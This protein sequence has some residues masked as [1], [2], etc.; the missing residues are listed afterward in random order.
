MLPSSQSQTEGAFELIYEED[1]LKAGYRLHISR[2]T[3]IAGHVFTACVFAAISFA[4]LAMAEGFLAG[5][6]SLGKAGIAIA[7]GAAL[8]YAIAYLNRSMIGFGFTDWLKKMGQ[9][10]GTTKY[11]YDAHR[12]V[13]E[14][15]MFG[16]EM[17]WTEAHGW[18][19]DEHILLIY[20]SPV[21]YYYLA[22]TKVP[23]HDLS[24]LTAILQTAKVP[25]L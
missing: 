12:L 4:A 13:I 18:T 15:R 21:F 20:R 17:N 7:I 25:R 11:I 14:D 23:D 1:N 10:A 9:N 6:G 19:E 22:K 5:A 2:Q 16:G 3:S 24:N 8:A